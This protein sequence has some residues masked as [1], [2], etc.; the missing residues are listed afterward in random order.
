[1]IKTLL[2]AA[3]SIPIFFTCAP[4]VYETGR[5]IPRINEPY[6]ISASVE[7][8]GLTPLSAA[9]LAETFWENTLPRDQAVNA[10]GSWG[11]WRQGTNIQFRTSVN[12]GNGRALLWPGAWAGAGWH[13]YFVTV[14][15]P[16][17]TTE[18][19]LYVDG[20]WKQPARRLEDGSLLWLEQEAVSSWGTASLET[21]PLVV[22]GCDCNIFGFV[23]EWKGVHFF[24][25][26]MAP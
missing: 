19:H 14:G 24:S 1:M 15:Y 17:G 3:A 20:E 10:P 6:T 26:S 13:T 23:P 9:F 8:T 18:V 11:L 2:S 25:I 21:E 5:F 12:S 7:D 4:G 16:V 22:G